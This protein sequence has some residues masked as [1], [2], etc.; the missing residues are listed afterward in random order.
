MITITHNSGRGPEKHFSITDAAKQAGMSRAW[1]TALIQ[2]GSV[3]AEHREYGRRWVPESE[4]RRLKRER[5]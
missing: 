5:K 3:V 1:L 2:R 4:I